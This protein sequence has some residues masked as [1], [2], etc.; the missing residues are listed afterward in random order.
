MTRPLKSLLKPGGRHRRS[1]DPHS[2]PRKAL[3]FRMAAGA[4][5]ILI[6]AVIVLA[7]VPHGGITAS[8]SVVRPKSIA[9]SHPASPAIS[10]PRTAG[11]TSV[12]KFGAATQRALRKLESTPQGRADLL[13]ALQ[14]SF[15][16]GAKIVASP[17]THSS[18]IQLDATCAPSISCGLSSSGG[19]HFWI[20]ASYA[21]AESANLWALQPYCWAALVPETGPV[22]AAA[23][24]SIGGI[25][26]AMVNNWPRMTN[27]GVWLAVYWWGIQDGRY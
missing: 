9:P 5:G 21:A 27:H 23:C 26:W 8:G 14:V 10:A 22:G 6:G 19:W 13:R 18:H 15:G 17:P 1:T 16:R 3:L 2:L 12:I 25:L 20:I 7:A 4:T 24:L 11:A